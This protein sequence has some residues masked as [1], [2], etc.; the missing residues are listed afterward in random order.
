LGNREEE[1]QGNNMNTPK[2]CD[3]CEHFGS[4]PFDI[5]ND[6]PY[7]KLEH[8]MGNTK[9]KFFKHWE[10]GKKKYEEEQ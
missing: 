4:S 3:Q 5:N 7:C 1:I 10:T 6:Y 9:C 2:P 8:E